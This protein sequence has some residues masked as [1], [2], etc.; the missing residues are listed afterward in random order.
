MKERL[1]SYYSIV[2]A[3][4]G[5]QALDIIAAESERLVSITENQLLLSKLDSQQIIADKENYLLDEQIR[6]CVILLSPEWEKKNISFSVELHAIPVYASADM[7]HHVWIN[8]LSN[9]IKYTPANGEI[10]VTSGMTA[11][12]VRISI[13]DTGIGMTEEEL[14]HI[15]A[16][17]YRA[18][19]AAGIKG[20]GLGLPIV[21]RILEMLDGRIEVKSLPGEG[22]SFT[23]ILPQ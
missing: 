8:L 17:Y 14:Q 3:G 13:S 2:C 20:L 10:S 12:S 4:D 23:V 18:D 7:L 5:V 15:F 1:K 22:S 11:D 6:Q 21:K 9:A 16:R 19:N